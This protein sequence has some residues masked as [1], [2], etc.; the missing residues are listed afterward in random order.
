M[1]NHPTIAGKEPWQARQATRAIQIPKERI[2]KLAER[3]NRLLGQ[4]LPD[5]QEPLGSQYL[6][7]N[8]SLDLET[9]DGR[10]VSVAVYVRT[11]PS[12]G[13]DFITGG[14][15]GARKSTNQ[16]V[17]IVEVNGS[18]PAAKLRKSIQ[19]SDVF[20]TLLFSVLIHEFT[21]VVDPDTSSGLQKAT[22]GELPAAK[23]IDFSEYY[24]SPKEVRAYLQ[25][26]VEEVAPRFGKM[27]AWKKVFGPGSLARVLDQTRTWKEIKGHLTEENRR[28]VLK[29]VYRALEDWREAQSKQARVLG[30]G[31]VNIHRYV[32]LSDEVQVL[33]LERDGLHYLAHVETGSS[34][35]FDLKMQ[36]AESQISRAFDLEVESRLKG[37]ELYRHE[38]AIETTEPDDKAV[39]AV[40]LLMD[41]MWGFADWAERAPE[42][43]PEENIAREDFHRI[44][45]KQLKDWKGSSNGLRVTNHP[46]WPTFHEQVVE[47]VKAKYGSKVRAYRG[48]HGKQAK[49]IL[50]G[51]PV[52][53]YKYSS[54]AVDK[55]AA[56]SYRGYQDYW[57]VVG[58]DFRPEEIALAPV[59]LPDYPE[60]NVLMKLAYDVEHSGD[61]VVVESPSGVVR[62][63]T[64]S[65]S[66]KRLAAVRQ[67]A[68]RWVARKAASHTP[69]EGAA[70]SLLEGD[71]S[72]EDLIQMVERARVLMDPLSRTM[73]DKDEVLAVLRRLQPQDGPAVSGI[74]VYHA[75]TP[76]HAKMLLKRGFLP[77]TKPRNLGGDYAPGRGLDVGLY[78]GVSP[79]AVESYGR[80]TLEVTV[81]RT[82]LAVPTE[83][84]QLGET[85][86]M[87]ALKGHDGAV[88]NDRLP[89]SAFQVVGGARYMLATRVAG[90]RG[91]D[92]LPVKGRRYKFFV[93][94]D[95]QGNWELSPFADFGALSAGKWGANASLA[96]KNEW[97][98]L[99]V[100]NATEHHQGFRKALDEMVAKYPELRDWLIM[101]DGPWG[102]VKDLVG[103][104]GP[105]ERDWSKMTFFH[106]TSL[107]AWEK[108]QVEGLRPRGDTNVNPAYGAGFGAAEGRVDAVYL[109]TQL[110][111]AQHASHDAA[112]GTGTTLA[113]LEVRGLDPEHVHPD[114]DSRAETAEG[115][116]ERIGSIAYAG[117]IPPENIRLRYLW[118]DDVDGWV[119]HASR[120]RVADDLKHLLLPPGATAE[121]GPEKGRSVTDGIAKYVSPH[122]SYRY[123]LYISGQAVSALQVMSR[124]KKSAQVAN[125]FTAPEFRRQGQAAKLLARA[126]KDFRTVN[127]SRNLSEEGRAWSQAVRSAAARRLAAKWVASSHDR[128][129]E[130]FQQWRREVK[131]QRDR[132][133]AV[134]LWEASNGRG[135]EEKALIEQAVGLPLLAAGSERAIF[136]LGQSVLKIAVQKSDLE[137]NLKEVELWKLSARHPKLRALL[138]PIVSAEG[139]GRWVEME[140]AQP[141]S[142]TP[143]GELTD[144]PVVF[145]DTK[146][147]NWGVHQ[148]DLK[149]LDYSMWSHRSATV[150]R[151]AT[152]KLYHVTFPENAASILSG[153]FRPSTEGEMGPGVYL[154]TDPRQVT[155]PKYRGRDLDAVEVAVSVRLLRLEAWVNLPLEVLRQLFGRE[156]GTT[157]YDK[158]PTRQKYDW[159]LLQSMV[160]REGCGGFESDFGVKNIVVFDA[161]DVRPI[162]SEQITRVAVRVAAKR[163]V[164]VAR[165][166]LARSARPGSK[167]QLSVHQGRFVVWYLPKYE[168][169]LPVVLEGLKRAEQ[170]YQNA[171]YTLPQRIPVLIAGRPFGS[172]R[173]IYTSAEG[174]FIQLVPSAVQT[175][176]DF[177]TFVHELAH[178]L[179][180][181]GITRGFMN[182]DINLKFDE[183]KSQRSPD[184]GGSPVERAQDGMK[185]VEKEYG[186]IVK[187]IRPGMEF[188]VMLPTGFMPRSPKELR[189]I[190]VVKKKGRGRGTKIVFEYLEPT[191]GEREIGVLGNTMPMFSFLKKV[192]LPGVTDAFMDLEERREK[193]LE[194]YNAAVEQQGGDAASAYQDPRSDWFPTEYAKTDAMEWFAELVTARLMAPAKMAPEARDWLDAM[195]KTGGAAAR[196]AARWASRT[197][198]ALPWEM[199]S[200]EYY[201]PFPPTKPGYR[202]LFH[203]T[204]AAFAPGILRQGLDP[205]KTREPYIWATDAS[206]GNGYEALVHFQVPQN[207]PAVTVRNRSVGHW[208]VARKVS[209]RDI[210]GV[211]LPW[212]D[213]MDVEDGQA[214]PSGFSVRSDS[215]RQVK[216]SHREY[217]E[218]AL[219]GGFSVPS[220]V[221]SEYGLAAPGTGRVAAR[222]RDKNLLR[223]LV[224]GRT[225]TLADVISGRYPVGVEGA[226][227]K[228]VVNARKAGLFVGREGGVTFFALTPAKAAPLVK[229][230]RHGGVYGS[231]T[232]SRL[233]GYT[234]TEI[235]EYV[236]FLRASGQDHLVKSAGVRKGSVSQTAV[237][238]VAAK[239][240][241]KKQVDKADGSGKT[242]VY[243]YS[244]GQI[245]HRNREK[246]KRVEGLRGKLDKLRSQVKKDLNSGDD[247]T[248]LTALAVG[249][250]DATYERVGNSQSAGDGHF[251]VTGWLVKHVKF[252]KGGHGKGK[253]NAT[254]SY[255]G[256]SGVKQEKV[257]DD[258]G[259]VAAL[260]KATKGKKGNG[261]ICEGEDCKVGAGDVNTYLKPYDITA[262]DLR[263]LHANSEMQ[264]RLKAIRSK[265]GTLPTDKKE[266]EKKLKE[267]FQEALEA[268]AEAVGHEPS[269]LKSQYLVPG[270][271]DGFLSGGKVMDK[272]TKKGSAGEERVKY[273]R[274]PHLPW[275]PGATSDDR[276]LTTT[277]HFEG[278]R[279]IVS[280]KLDGENCTIGRNYTHARSP[281][282]RHHP[283][284]SWVK[285][286]QS[287]VGHELPDGWRLCGENLYAQHTIG[288][289][290]LPSYFMMFSVWDERNVCQSWDDTVDLARMLNAQTVP[291]LYD[292][293]WDPDR[294]TDIFDGKSKLSTGPAEGY[295]VRLADAFHYSQFGQS[296]AKFVRAKFKADLEENVAESGHWM[297]QEVVPNKLIKKGSDIPPGFLEG[298]KIKDTLYHGTSAQVGPGHSL[299]S[300]LGSEFGIYVSSSHRYARMYGSKLLRVL[301]N[302]KN[303][304]VVEGKYEI[305]PGDLTK[306]DARRLQAEGY[307]SVVVGSILRPSEVVLFDPRQVWVLDAGRMAAEALITV[308]YLE[309]L[310]DTAV[311]IPN[312]WGESSPTARKLR[313]WLRGLQNEFSGFEPFPVS[314]MWD[315]LAESG[316]A[317]EELEVLRRVTPPRVRAP[318]KGPD[319]TDAMQAFERVSGKSLAFK[320]LNPE[321]DDDLP[322]DILAW[323]KTLKGMARFV[324][325]QRLWDSQVKK[326]VFFRTGHGTEDASWANGEILLRVGTGSSTP[327]RRGILVH[328]LGHALEEALD[329]MVTPWDDTPYGQ[330]PYVSAY[331][332]NNATE[333]FAESFRA[334]LMEPR[335]LQRTAPA[336]Y[337]DMKTRLQGNRKVG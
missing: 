334:L 218:A 286:L 155:G 56:E 93:Y 150:Q 64:M 15:T 216:G 59:V 300:D 55:D 209:P 75:T 332:S 48:I 295:V 265:G 128:A 53:V 144:L 154:T 25:E 279:V 219:E 262:K 288:Y 46:Y 183:V 220:R 201:Q 14:A 13:R 74:K 270:L 71:D 73:V 184:V 24:N 191:Q 101:F 299:R 123:V 172:S 259:L 111:M 62:P 173:S 98:N 153:G 28:Y 313:G 105:Q 225:H 318:K 6:V 84:A 80:V 12:N 264:D 316:E 336:K 195:V 243:E 236:E 312:G 177:A 125:V 333:D 278:K 35:S 30:V 54:W 211:H 194:A 246:A 244:K 230:L 49:E 135:P 67:L 164:R 287:Q 311:N 290:E 330:E 273:P 36:G 323:A 44:L 199:S 331:A 293:P 47:A 115:S 22:R 274:S 282:S 124:D 136:D 130:A 108:I 283:S 204:S 148:G 297:Q 240:K 72:I 76:Q 337:A 68:A 99:M 145:Y 23:D 138:V 32:R 134:A 181:H 277:A 271:A 205:Q 70:L 21:H 137:N 319:F 18:I 248:R 232:F 178:Y 121:I 237:Q 133:W 188:Q 303:P 104:A 241:N 140:K 149:L 238:R 17:V 7:K 139:S 117:V 66:R 126:R 2:R 322:Q 91:P 281:D 97:R 235:E 119:R 63:R 324:P 1:S 196:V 308:P 58:V 234:E 131:E 335:M 255:V 146:P 222:Y 261:L 174:G 302:A 228:D 197:T 132:N 245:E 294:I 20:L 89:P 263:G 186:Q 31:D 321:T 203:G 83:Q 306:E 162:R 38:E 328:E 170:L 325:A 168:A 329:L 158:L 161:G 280:E 176:G 69:A 165:Q 4:R 192:T 27:P 187:A 3:I 200:R 185:R 202:S 251:G 82:A 147:D 253:G 249:L 114:E 102:E 122:G 258:S 284:R 118:D 257:V 276:I 8:L 29:G 266:R 175:K 291:I 229:Y 207:D 233:L 100:D 213:S 180:N 179:H 45:T 247:K 292:G 305:N 85:D 275:S 206:V 296:L 9:L 129:F 223:T 268:T 26:I 34:I 314:E 301:V 254:I 267:E 327:V 109:T 79:R 110:N 272:F 50:R 256:K 210:L 309:K 152:R 320:G 57:V 95:D 113:I 120:N 52:R 87:R 143:T 307:D 94:G 86:P 217:V 43:P 5:S 39:Q 326:V 16:P 127:H 37:V 78:V 250:M 227:G 116:L 221:L 193:A 103:G 33:H 289:D 160:E 166:H 159:G 242:T 167:G 61:E 142:H 81:P 19:G 11:R 226:G 96:A 190:K 106:G 107:A 157:L 169:G 156:E 163:A 198:P 60:P 269:T 189:P 10:D 90:G 304:K 65:K 141:V 317:P 112:R 40:K 214:E 215:A 151:V 92:T 208:T 51:D 310:I 41:P 77:E 231:V 260:K 171:G 315:L 42:S 88:A 182:A 224:Q 239:F 285:G 212:P 252:G 298:S